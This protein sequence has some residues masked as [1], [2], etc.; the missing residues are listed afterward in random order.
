MRQGAA[1]TAGGY[2]IDS[3]LRFNDDDSAYLSW[4][5]S[6]AGNRKTWTW[7][8]WVK[9][10]NVLSSVGLFNGGASGAEM[11]C[12]IGSNAIHIY[13]WNG[14]YVWQLNTTTKQL[15]RDP[16]AWYHFVISV[17][18]T[19]GT[20]SNR[21]KLYVN[22]SQITEFGSGKEVYPSQNHDTYFNNNQPQQIGSA[23][24]WAKL[25]GYLAEV[26]F[27]DG[28]ALAPTDFGEVDATYGHWKAK[29][30]TGSYTGN[31]F[32]LPFTNDT[33]ND[34][35]NT[36]IW[37]GDGASSRSMGGLGFQP[38]FIWGKPRSQ[39]ASHLLVDTVRGTDKIL[40]S[41]DVAAE[42]TGQTVYSSF[43]SDGFTLG[44][45][46]PGWWYNHASHTSVAWAW[47][48]GGAASS[49]TNGS[50][51][52]QVSANP[53]Q[54]FSIVSYTGT[55]SNATVGHGI[56]T[57]ELI[58]I[59]QRTSHSST[60]NGDGNWIVYYEGGPYSGL[61]RL[62]FNGTHG[63]T[64][65]GAPGPHWNSTAPSSTLVSLGTS[66]NV[67][68]SGST[69]IAY[70]W[71]SVAGYSKIGSYTGNGSTTG[72]VITTGF[73]V[74]WILIK[75]SDSADSWTIFDN[76]RSPTN[77]IDDH[78]RA[79]TSGAE[80]SPGGSPAVEVNL[81]NDGF[82]ILNA[83][84]QIN[85]SGGTYIYMA[86]ADT[87]VIGDV[88]N[89]QSGLKNHWSGVNLTASDVMLDSPTNNFCT[90]NPLANGDATAVISEGNTKASYS[91]TGSAL[92][93][94]TM[95]VGS[96]KWYWETYIGAVPSSARS[97]I[98]LG[99]LD[100]ID[101][102]GS[103]QTDD[104]VLWST[105][106]YRR[107]W[108]YGTEYDNTY[109]LTV[110]GD[111]FQVAL[112]AGTGKIW[113]G[114]NNSWFTGNPST[115]TTPIATHSGVKSWS[116]VSMISAG[117]SITQ[118]YYLN[119]GQDATFAGNKSPNTTYSDGKYGEFHYQPP[120]GFKAL[121]SLNISDPAVV[122]GEHFNAVTYTG[123]GGTQSITGAGFQP[124]FVWAKQRDSG[125][126][127]HVLFDSVRGTTKMLASDISS[128]EETQ[129]GVT[130]FNSDGFTVGSWSGSN[131]NTA[132]FISWLWKAGGTAVS[133]TNG[134]ITSSVSANTDGGFSI[135]SYT[136]NSSNAS[137][138]HGLNL[139]PE[140]VIVKQR[141]GGNEWI[142]GHQYIDSTPW[143]G[144]TD[145]LF[146][147]FTDAA[148]SSGEWNST[149]P[150]NTLFYV[151]GSGRVNASSGTYIAYC[152]HS[153]DGFSKFGSYTGN[154]NADGAFIYTGFQPKYVLIKRTDSAVSW[155]VNDGARDIDNATT[156]NLYPN[157][158]AAEDSGT[159]RFDFVSNGFKLRTSSGAFNGTNPFIYMAFAEY[160]FKYSNAR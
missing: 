35:F 90:W 1:G 31:S 159:E 22:G 160:P 150:T 19:Q 134:S 136:G 113:F 44:A 129:S 88:T 4:T 27:I 36:V 118:Q 122:P 151:S 69:Y 125:G 94:G 138:G 8:G 158:S 73:K 107:V 76:T 66:G 16:S 112:D 147:E 128:A 144:T 20:A 121:C 50:I 95:G 81:A 29:E 25:D 111:I 106:D 45:G 156:Y 13:D 74:G 127:N 57:P 58:I 32:Y 40:L 89:D 141:S 60:G 63:D 91:S 59:K 98:G 126:G 38:D 2:E 139:P 155:I 99:D 104:T 103:G 9:L 52:S 100:T 130:A 87:S 131:N 108:N 83:N 80:Y 14:S 28:S 85:A 143:N 48:A 72:P 39:A 41:N 34:H 55:G 116:P 7:S 149:A 97:S 152:W 18:T 23:F 64:D 51:T 92:L 84:G 33:T 124:D 115:G 53:D 6:S 30:Y 109:P 67:N 96:G 77:P 93:P 145:R 42:Y 82:E 101:I 142:V 12:T 102:T 137:I 105:G 117:L 46:A 68:G 24:G 157:S 5:P 65:A 79:D 140:M 10:G 61:G 133:N 17:D 132:S 135:I 86:I 78:L 49:N 54:G 110:A 154:G 26:N 75:R 153:V 3:S 43:D 123:N 120:S 148:G 15:F 114:V 70:C 146:L 71:H 119:T 47:K 56:G 62:I 37:S 21:V 11:S